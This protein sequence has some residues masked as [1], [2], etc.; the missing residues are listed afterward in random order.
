MTDPV[1]ATREEWQAARLQLLEEEKQ[2]LRQADAVAAKRRT[3]PWVPVEKDY[4][5]ET[6]TG[7]ASLSDLF[8]GKSQL[9]VQHFMF[10]VDADQGCPS[11]SMWADNY[12]PMCIH[13]QQRNVSFVVASRAPLDKLLAYRKRMGWAFNWVSSLNNTFNFDFHVSATE[14]EQAKGE[15]Q[16]NY[17]T[18]KTQMSDLHGTS[19]FAKDGEGKVYHTYSTYARGVERMNAVYGFLDLTPQ[20]RAEDDLPFSMAWVRRHDEY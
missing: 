2:L 8:Q 13:M 7:A 1:V 11:C 20:G 10:G 9:V 4:M 3:L 19:V 17:R 5:F 6:E 15:M 12:D 16:Y 18:I 14:D